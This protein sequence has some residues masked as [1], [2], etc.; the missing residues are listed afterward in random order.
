[1]ASSIHF[2][3]LK[4]KA[5]L[6][7]DYKGDIPNGA[8]EKFPV[9]LVDHTNTGLG[10]DETSL[11]PVLYDNGINYIYVVHKDLYILAMTR[12]NTNVFAIMIFLNN[13]VK[14]LINYFKSLQEE[15]IRDNF[16]I[17]YE[18]LDEMMDF[19]L[20]QI[21]D[22]KILKE[23]ITQ[24]SYTL[25]EALGQIRA[26][27]TGQQAAPKLPPSTLTKSI[28][29]RSEGIVYKKNEAFLDVIESINMTI[30]AKGQ[31]LSSEILGR[32]NV[33]SNLSGMPDLRLGLNE[34]FLNSGARLA[35]SGA[36]VAS[37]RAVTNELEDVKFHQCVRLSKFE[38]EKIITFVPPDGEFDLMTYRILSPSIN[39]LFVVD[40]KMQNHSNTRLEILLK[41]RTNF[42]P[43][44]V[45]N[46]LEIYIPCPDDI[47]SP[48][49]G[50]TKGSV[51]YLPDK[52]CLCWKFKSING[53]KEYSMIAELQLPSVHSGDEYQLES[54]RKR[55]LKL[56]FQIPYYTTSGLQVRYL[57]INES[58]L[59]YQAYPWVR[60]VTQSGD[61][62]VIRVS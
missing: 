39:Q 15:A 25:E 54:F 53:G 45:C 46:N 11:P 60:Y 17:M 20:P 61:D 31:T 34:K 4:G 48:K 52:S 27:S 37:D 35:E 43:K 44:L 47:S 14:V 1:M 49:F 5:L 12:E 40:Y 21:T 33:K 13:L 41:V 38:N 10:S 50:R 9:L 32:I 62:Y 6:S 7:R 56:N 42:K 55:P 51:K 59:N 29:W 26:S 24:K 18:L 22:P 57:R 23:Y 58:K 8:L 19:G 36:G 28:S 2:L 3:D 30:N 16:V